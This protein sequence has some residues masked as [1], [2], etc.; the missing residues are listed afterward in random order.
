[1][2]LTHGDLLCTD[3][4]AY[5]ELRS[6]VRDSAW[7]RRVLELPLATRALLAG[8]AR[9]GSR[10]HIRAAPPRIM[11]VNADAVTKL[12]RASGVELMIHGHT[13]RP[14]IHDLRVDGRETTRAV[15]GAWYESGH[16]LCLE[17]GRLEARLLA[18]RDPLSR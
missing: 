5:Q 1:V 16:V 9:A 15:L 14:A 4:H 18:R 12:F 13:H 2:L 11:D 3:D 8:A 6:T 7:Q 17:R 10:A